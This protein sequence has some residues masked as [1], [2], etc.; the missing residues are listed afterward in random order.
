MNDKSNWYV[1]E[2]NGQTLK[3]T[4]KIN[5]DDETIKVFESED[6][7]K[8]WV[9]DNA[10]VIFLTP[11]RK[12]FLQMSLKN[13]NEVITNGNNDNLE[14]YKY[15]FGSPWGAVYECTDLQKEYPRKISWLEQYIASCTDTME[16]AS[17]SYVSLVSNTIENTVQTV[18]RKLD[19]ELR[20]ENPEIA[21]KIHEIFVDLEKNYKY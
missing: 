2:E 18:A 21:N 4:D 16:H 7:A 15:Y 11:D 8:L 12:E 14:F 9:K 13:W 5:F 17:S 6:A 10:Q 19:E 20:Q 3:I 1:C